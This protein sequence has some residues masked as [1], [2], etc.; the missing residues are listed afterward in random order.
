MGDV[1]FPWSGTSPGWTD[2]VELFRA[3]GLRTYWAGIDVIAW[4]TRLSKITAKTSP[5]RPSAPI[6]PASS[7]TSSSVPGTRLVQAPPDGG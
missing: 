4:G 3:K 1:N 6:T 2:P 5:P 7:S